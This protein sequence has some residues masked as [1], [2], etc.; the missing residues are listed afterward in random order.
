MSLGELSTFEEKIVA[1][2]FI[3]KNSEISEEDIARVPWIYLT[4]GCGEMSAVVFGGNSEIKD[5]VASFD[6]AMGLIIVMIMKLT[7]KFEIVS[8]SK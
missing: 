3:V 5:P 4:T 2:F 8:K 7:E 1:V 6:I